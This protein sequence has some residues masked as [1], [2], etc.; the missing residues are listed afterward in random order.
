[1]GNTETGKIGKRGTFVI[2]TKLRKRFGMK[3]G[4]FVVAE[5]REDGILIR[6][7][8]VLP[9]EVY[10]PQRVAQFLLSN[11]VDAEDYAWAIE[12]V[13]RMGLDPGKI[14]HVKPTEG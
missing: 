2:P 11:A 14:D 12:E 1:M 6:P 7:A 9:V 13:C 8:E 10:T 5:E 3:E 4:S